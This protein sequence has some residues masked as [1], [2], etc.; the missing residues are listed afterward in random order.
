[1]TLPAGLTPGV[2]LLTPPASVAEAVLA[3]A[4]GAVSWVIWMVVVA[5]LLGPFGAWPSSTTT[6]MTRSGLVWSGL[7]RPFE[8]TIWCSA[9]W[10]CACVADPVRCTVM[11]PATEVSVVA[12][13]PPGRAPLMVSTSLL[14][15]LVSV[16]VADAIL[17]SSTSVIRAVPVT[18]AAVPLMV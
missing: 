2:P 9:A 6:V 7:A 17:V 3:L 1:M 13:M 10:Y 8:N 18:D 4:T 11:T 5:V 15:A 12:T 16:T 14:W